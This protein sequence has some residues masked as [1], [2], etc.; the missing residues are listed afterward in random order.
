MQSLVKLSDY[1]GYHV[2]HYLLTYSVQ[3][4]PSFNQL[5][6]YQS[7]PNFYDFGT[8]I[9]E[10]EN[11]EAIALVPQKHSKHYL[12]VHLLWLLSVT[13]YPSSNYLLQMV[14]DSKFLG[15]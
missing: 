7:H 1:C 9:L 4:T 13:L 3:Q 2:L 11:Q 5:P 12:S 14:I 15:F 8:A 6:T 10:W